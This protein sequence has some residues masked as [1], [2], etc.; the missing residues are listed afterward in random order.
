MTCRRQ[1]TLLH[2]EAALWSFR[3][4]RACLAYE[5][6]HWRKHRCE[7]INSHGAQ[8]DRKL[9]KRCWLKPGGSVHPRG[10]KSK[11]CVEPGPCG[12]SS[13]TSS[14]QKAGAFLIFPWGLA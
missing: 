3:Q 10:K 12:V 11:A 8:R 13:W 9:G 4:S 6:R 2:P 7:V 14:L 1:D 5:V